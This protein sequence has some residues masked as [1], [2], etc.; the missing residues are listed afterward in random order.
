M[1]GMGPLRRKNKIAY[2]QEYNRVAWPPCGKLGTRKQRTRGVGGG[3]PWV[4][5]QVPAALYKRCILDHY[6]ADLLGNYFFSLGEQFD[7]KLQ[8]K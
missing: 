7:R 1:M 6:N 8:R 3:L 2:L 5:E 4:L